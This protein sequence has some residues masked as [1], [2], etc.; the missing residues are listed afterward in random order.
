MEPR[1]SE[2]QSMK[3]D[4]R[5]KLSEVIRTRKLKLYPG[6]NKDPGSLPRKG[7]GAAC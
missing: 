4:R 5:S 7:Q 2:I 3:D 6:E 1:A